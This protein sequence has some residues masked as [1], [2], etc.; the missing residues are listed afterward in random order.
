MQDVR[1]AIFRRGAEAVSRLVDGAA[2]LYVCPLCLRGFDQ[3]AL[4]DRALTVEHAPPE[5]I[6]GRVV[7][8]TCTEC[9]HHSGAELDHHMTKA[10]QL[11]AF[12]RGHDIQ[13]KARLE[14]GAVEQRGRF[15]WRDGALCWEGAPKANRLGVTEQ[16]IDEM[17]RLVA[18]GEA[19]DGT[20]L[21][22]TLDF[23]VDERR[24]S[25]GWMRSAYLIA[26]AA[27][28]YRYIGQPAFEPVRSQINDPSTDGFV[29][30]IAIDHDAPDDR[31]M[32]FL[33][34]EREG[35]GGLLL[36]IGKRRIWLPHIADLDY[37]S[38][39][40]ALRHT[41]LGQRQVSGHFVEWPHVARFALDL[42]H[43]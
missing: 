31:R 2:D 1:A 33:T 17:N 22:V 43:E 40:N 16:F 41:N 14:V 35:I 7:C 23:D 37:V 15:S 42:E 18:L 32:L 20:E 28:G 13:V 12:A 34:S 5:S 29:A 19:A 27:L 4:E 10:E 25:I 11:I 9:N 8:L 24:A 6:G 26:F 39:C 21:H 38:R 36:G 30:P 3:S